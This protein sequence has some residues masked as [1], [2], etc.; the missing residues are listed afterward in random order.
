MVPGLKTPLTFWSTCFL[1][2]CL[3]ERISRTLFMSSL[4]SVGSSVLR[5]VS[6]LT[7]MSAEMETSLK[8][9][10]I[11]GRALPSAFSMREATWSWSACG[12]WA[13]SVLPL[14]YSMVARIGWSEASGGDVGMED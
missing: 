10:S 6:S 4:A 5:S 11:C 7:T 13:M 1:T 14:S 9:T 8:R 12:P 2:T 3:L